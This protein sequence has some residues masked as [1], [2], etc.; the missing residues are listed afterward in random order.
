MW[1]F[2]S[3]ESTV[4]KCKSNNKT[5]KLAHN[6]KKLFI[7][8]YFQRGPGDQV[9]VSSMGR[10]S[11]KWPRQQSREKRVEVEYKY[12]LSSRTDCCFSTMLS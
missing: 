7:I 5:H 1:F 12:Y 6:Y 8:D 9:C 4:Y 11:G 10:L 3:P 2:F